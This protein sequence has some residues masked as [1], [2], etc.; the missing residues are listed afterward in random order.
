MKDMAKITVDATRESIAQVAA[1]V[2]GELEKLSCPFKTV[3]QINIAVDELYS[4]IVNYAYGGGAGQASVTVQGLDANSVSVTFEDSG[5]PYDPLAKPDPDTTLGAEERKIGGL[6]IF[7]VK[8]TMDSMD[9]KYE[10]NKNVFTIV[11][12]W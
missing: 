8:K 12:K 5:V 3:A 9:Y 2:E 11:K 10:D 7:I 1:F 4:N 6:G